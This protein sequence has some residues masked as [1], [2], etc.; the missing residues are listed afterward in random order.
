[1]KSSTW[2][3]GPIDKWDNE[4][5]QWKRYG[6]REVILKNLDNSSNLNDEFLNE[7][8]ISISNFYLV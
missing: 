7:V 5:Q 1:M 2:L 3:D 6:V 8:T 4:K